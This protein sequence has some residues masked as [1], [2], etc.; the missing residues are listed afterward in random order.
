[1]YNP[2]YK[3]NTGNELKCTRS[4]QNLHSKHSS[5]QTILEQKNFIKPMNTD[6][7]IE[8]SESVLSI[9][10]KKNIKPNLSNKSIMSIK[11]HINRLQSNGSMD[12]SEHDK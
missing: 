3:S 12:I 9:D 6:K 8:K 1:M 5:N 7:T 2:A 4:L 11:Q 10:R